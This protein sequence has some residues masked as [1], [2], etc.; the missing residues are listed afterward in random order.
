M[1]VLVLSLQ[2]EKRV[3]LEIWCTQKIELKQQ[4]IRISIKLLSFYLYKKLENV[5]SNIFFKNSTKTL[6]WRNIDEK[7]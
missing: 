2:A 4:K 7:C 1:E 6:D 3:E 5:I